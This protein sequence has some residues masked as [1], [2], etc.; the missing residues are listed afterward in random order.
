MSKTRADDTPP[1]IQ[2]FLSMLAAQRG[3]SANTLS[4]Y[5]R[6]LTAAH[7]A[8]GD[9]E[10]ATTATLTTLGQHWANLAPASVARKASALRQFYG[11]LVDEN[12]REDDPS[13]ALPRLSPR[14]PLPRL[15]AMPISP[16]S[17]PAPK[18]KPVAIKEN[19]C[20]P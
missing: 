16:P 18:K 8:L 20:A 2:A 12:W 1:A 6:D 11:F 5:R 4:A 17:S 3:A 7:A 13:P 14:R 19:P 9:L 10:A 15:L